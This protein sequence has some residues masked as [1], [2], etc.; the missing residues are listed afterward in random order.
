[1]QAPPSSAP[2]YAC[3]ARVV[4]TGWIL[5]LIDKVIDKDEEEKM[6]GSSLLQ[7]VVVLDEEGK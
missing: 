7:R 3:S 2:R 1:M 4:Y 6:V 5:K